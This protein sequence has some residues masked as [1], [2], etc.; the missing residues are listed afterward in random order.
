MAAVPPSV[1]QPGAMR[2]GEE[3]DSPS[4]STW[5]AAN[6]L[7]GEL[8]VEQFPAGHSNLTY[9]VTIGDRELVLRRP[10]FGAQVGHDM[11]R[12]WR[13]LT[14]LAEWDQAPRPVAFC[15]D[16]E[17][18]GAPFYLME[19]RRG[20]VLRG[21]K[22]PAWL[23]AATTAG[24]CRAFASTLA[25]IHDMNLAA[26]GLD[27]FGRPQGYVERQVSGWAVRYQRAATSAVPAMDEVIAWLEANRP[28]D[29]GGALIHNDFKFDNLVLESA[30]PTR[31]VGVLDW[32]MATVG[33]PLMD[34]G[35]SLAYWV[36]A[37]DPPELQRLAFGPSAAAGA[38]DRAGLVELYQ[39][40]SGRA[41]DEP[42]F[43][44]VYGLFKLAVIVQQIYY[45]YHH[46]Y[47]SD[48]RFARMEGMVAVLADTAHRAARTAAISLRSG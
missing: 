14:A 32:E 16:E 6:G 10:P 2:E 5:L 45:R 47:T 11:G 36:E 8:R 46:G 44:Y 40:A 1:D 20:V 31:I 15:D 4:L 30:D 26:I 27:G 38:P 34:L 24:L 28:P 23:D 19:R 22:P 42:V 12:E 18:L 48:S 37:A 17:V 35:T 7:E 43:Y 9:L 13:V 41:V 33:D 3:L 21:P 25:E 39:A 29:S